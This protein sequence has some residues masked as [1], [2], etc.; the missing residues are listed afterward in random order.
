MDH[1]AVAAAFLCFIEHR[2]RTIDEIDRSFTF[3]D[4]RDAKRRRNCEMASNVDFIPAM[5]LHCR[6]NPLRNFV[7]I[8]ERAFWAVTPR[9]SS[10]MRT[11]VLR[12]TRLRGSKAA[13][14]EGT[15]RMKCQNPSFFM[16][17][18]GSTGLAMAEPS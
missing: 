10:V 11:R 2:V 17:F 8:A 7:I 13:N 5:R 3:A 9:G 12:A 18:T 15:R 14:S 4:V 16:G 1:G 6:P